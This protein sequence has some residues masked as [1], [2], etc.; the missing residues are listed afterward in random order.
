M[1]KIKTYKQEFLNFGF[2]VTD[3]GNP[4]CVLCYR[5]LSNSSMK[6]NKLVRHLMTE[7]NLNVGDK[8]PEYFQRKLRELET[9]KDPI[10]RLCQNDKGKLRASYLVSARIAKTK[11]PFTIGESLILPAAVDI[12][13]EVIIRLQ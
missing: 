6:R 1:A 4:Q 13:R 8:S 10:E 9:Q 12:C 5:V 3:T 2:T 11:T 7:H